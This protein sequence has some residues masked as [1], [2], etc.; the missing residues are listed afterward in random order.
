MGSKSQPRA[1]AIQRIPVPEDERTHQ[2][3][4]EAVEDAD[5]KVRT[6]SY[7][8]RICGKVSDIRFLKPAASGVTK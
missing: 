5:P 4:W 1:D 6:R 7:K 2:H 8:C 3:E